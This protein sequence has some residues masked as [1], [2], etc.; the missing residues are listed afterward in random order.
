M[1]P[2]S[3]LRVV[4]TLA[5]LATFAA[6]APAGAEEPIPDRPRA[7]AV[8]TDAPPEIDG[9][10]TDPAWQDAALIRR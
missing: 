5:L 2:T 4:C 6:S 3:S 9:R 7:T 10:L 1:L 8:R